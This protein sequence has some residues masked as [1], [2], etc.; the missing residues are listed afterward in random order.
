MSHIPLDYILIVSNNVFNE[1]VTSPS[2]HAVVLL[3]NKPQIHEQLKTN[4]N[5]S[6]RKTLLQQEDGYKSIANQQRD[7]NTQNQINQPN[8]YH[9]MLWGWVE[10]SNYFVPSKQKSFTFILS[11][12]VKLTK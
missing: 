6:S 2:Q 8:P 12:S 11:Q 4:S 7:K 10:F 3:L 5:P 9:L 1:Y